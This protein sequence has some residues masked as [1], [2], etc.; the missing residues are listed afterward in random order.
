MRIPPGAA[1][2]EK[3]AEFDPSPRFTN[4]RTNQGSSEDDEAGDIRKCCHSRL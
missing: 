4:S 1:N 2:L 3:F